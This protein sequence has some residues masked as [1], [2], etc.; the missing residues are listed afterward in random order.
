MSKK[1]VVIYILKKQIN[2]FTIHLAAFTKQF[3]DSHI[4]NQN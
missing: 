3:N 4:I 1:R 2:A